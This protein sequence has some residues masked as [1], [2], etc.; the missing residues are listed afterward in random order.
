MIK[1]TDKKTKSSRVLPVFTR[2][3][4][5]KKS[6]AYFSGDELAAS[7]WVNKYAMKDGNGNFLEDS[8]DAMHK[9]M[10]AEFARIER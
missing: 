2:E 8:P 10:A 9:R 3:E 5:M 4:V 6:L 1:S 7:T